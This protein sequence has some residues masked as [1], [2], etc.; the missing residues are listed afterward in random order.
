MPLTVRWL[1]NSLVIVPFLA[2][3]SVFGNGA[4]AAFEV[5]RRLRELLNAPGWGFTLASRSLVG[6]ELGNVTRTGRKSRAGTSSGS[7]T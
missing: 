6:E 7:Q 5:A 4:V 2:I 1:D 3:V